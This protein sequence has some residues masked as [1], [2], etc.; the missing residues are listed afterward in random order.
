VSDFLLVDPW[1]TALNRLWEILEADATFCA[2]FKPANRIKL[3]S[4][5]GKNPLKETIND[6]DVPEIMIDPTTAVEHQ[7]F[8]SFNLDSVQSF[9]IQIT[10]LD[11]RLVTPEGNGANQ[12]RWLV[13]RLLSQQGDDLG[14]D[15]IYKARITT[16]MQHYVDPI[17]RGTKGWTALLTVTANLA[18]PKFAVNAVPWTAPQGVWRVGS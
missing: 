4:V 12:L 14:T 9:A 11:L 17:L 15:F 18:I 6:A 1:T 5:G 13:Y 3:T 2:K 7:A 10:T 8:T 16:A